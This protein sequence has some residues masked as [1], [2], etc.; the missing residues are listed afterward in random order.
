MF[1]SKRCAKN[2]RFDPNMKVLTTTPFLQD[3]AAPVTLRKIQEN[4]FEEKTDKK[5][6]GILSSP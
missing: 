4:L 5:M 3:K 1:S 6:T 2:V